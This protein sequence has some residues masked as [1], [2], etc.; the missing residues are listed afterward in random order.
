MAFLFRGSQPQRGAGNPIDGGEGV[1]RVTR[2]G[3]NQPVGNAAINSTPREMIRREVQ[4]VCQKHGYAGGL[5]V[6]ISIPGGLEIAAKTFNPRWG[7]R[8]GFL[9]W[10]PAALSCL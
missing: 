9:C 2:P 1:G 5:E 10:A 7:S 8:E 6:I 3:L 4:E